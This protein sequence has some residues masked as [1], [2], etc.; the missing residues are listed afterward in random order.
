MG[1]VWTIARKDLQQRLRD[2]S[3]YIFG[4]LAPLGLAVVL[5][6]IIPSEEALSFP[7]GV[8][9]DDGGALAAA[10]TEDV[11]GGLGDQ[12]TIERFDSTDAA[13]EA[14]ESGDLTAAYVVPRGFSDAATTGQAPPPIRLLANPDRPIG[15]SV[16]AAIADG[17]LG[18]LTATRAA[19]AGTIATGGDPAQAPAVAAAAGSATSPIAL[20]D[21]ASEN[22]RLDAATGVAAGMA[23]FFL[24]F[25]VQFG[26]TGL[27][28]EQ[29]LGT[30]PR[31]LASPI[32]QWSVTAA[33]G[34]VAVGLGIVS[35]VGLAVGTTLLLGATWGDPLAVGVLIVAGVLAAVG[36]MGV[37]ASFA[38]TA[39]GAQAAGSIVAV[40]LGMFGGSF[41]PVTGAGALATLSLATPHAWFLRGL[42]DLQAGG[43]LSEVLTEAVALL[44]IAL[45]FLSLA[46]VLLRR[47]ALA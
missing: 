29:R 15:V 25:T 26:V 22:R 36:I 27:L 47:K 34:L 19:V 46:A 43:G 8:V 20:G 41:F 30:M 9:D 2:R 37:A 32:P 14:V 33:K 40:V 5:A 44:V 11:L 28:E 23:V 45:V 35:M 42:G 7:F 38:E 12:F 10:F 39:E 3:A 6:A 24:L 21:L 1:P 13:E 4:L 31:L 16:A 17:F 18:R